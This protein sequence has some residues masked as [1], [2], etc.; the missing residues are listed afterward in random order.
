MP[1]DSLDYP[2]SVRWQ[3]LLAPQM[4]LVELCS[5]DVATRAALPQNGA[6]MLIGSQAEFEMTN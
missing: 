6:E 4:R 3:H 2:G 5:A 1:V